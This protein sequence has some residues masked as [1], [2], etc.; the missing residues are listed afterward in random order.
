MRE[1]VSINGTLVAPDAATVSVFDSGFMQGVGLFET[2][3]AYN[4]RAFQL[5]A[6]VD[7]LVASARALGWT[8]PIDGDDIAADVTSLLSHVE[9]DDARVRITVTTGSLRVVDDATP[10]LTVVVTASGGAGY[11]KECYTRGVTLALTRFRQN[12]HDPTTGHKTTSYFARLAA[13]REAHGTGAFEALALTPEGAVAEC[14]I[15]NLFI[16]H[17]DV[18]C[19]PPLDTPV[20]P[21]ITR[22]RV[23]EAA[24]RLGVPVREAPLTLDDLRGAD[25]AFL[26]SSVMEIV[27]VVRLGREPIGTEKPGDVTRTL[28]EAYVALINAECAD[29]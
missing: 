17:D 18:L 6:H 12:P 27:P 28:A 11:P 5:D 7:R 15:S 13:L 19:T 4:S 20:L 29:G 8:T 10:Q 24:V 25:E 2:L 3:R 14:A 9:L 22:A 1:L 26:T 16:V 21:G 23:I